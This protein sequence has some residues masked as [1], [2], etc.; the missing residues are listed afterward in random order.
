MRWNGMGM[1]MGPRHANAMMMN[2]GEVSPRNDIAGNNK[3]N[4]E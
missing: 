4:V 1:G 2:S 3:E